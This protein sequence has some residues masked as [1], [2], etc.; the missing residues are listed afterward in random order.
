[1]GTLGSRRLSPKN[2]VILAGDP[3]AGGH[4]ESR[5]K[6]A[7]KTSGDR[8]SRGGRLLAFCL[9]A[10]ARVPDV[11]LP[12]DRQSVQVDV[13]ASI[14]VDVGAADL[15]PEGLLAV[16][17]DGVNV[18]DCRVGHVH[19]LLSCFSPADFRRADQN[20]NGEATRLRL[21]RTGPPDVGGSGRLGADQAGL[22]RSPVTASGRGGRRV[23]HL[24]AEAL[25]P[26]GSARHPWAE[27]E[28]VG[29]AAEPLGGTDNKD[30]CRREPGALAGM[31][32]PAGAWLPS[33]RVGFLVMVPPT[34]GCSIQATVKLRTPGRKVL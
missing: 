19:P 29:P 1:M 2:G 24:S 20:A 25:W 10:R 14:L 31:P 4:L 11:Q 18:F 3:S 30:L 27:R 21:R 16:P 9:P 32:W 13:Q 28:P 8:L 12:V 26:R 7:A 15:L 17:D 22:R 6:A 5:K 33:G 23:P 34:L